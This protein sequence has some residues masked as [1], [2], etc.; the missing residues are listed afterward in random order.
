MRSEELRCPFGTFLIIIIIAE[1]DTTTPH[2]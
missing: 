1:G 2:S